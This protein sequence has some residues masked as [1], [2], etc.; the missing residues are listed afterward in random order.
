MMSAPAP[1]DPLPRLTAQ[2]VGLEEKVRRLEAALAA[3]GRATTVSDPTPVG[4]TW[5]PLRPAPDPDARFVTLGRVLGG[6]AHDLNNLLA[7]VQGYAEVLLE[8]LPADSPHREA[9]VTIAAV[10]DTAAGVVEHVQDVARSEVSSPA[11]TDPSLEVARLLR[12]LRAVCGSGV[13]VDADL[14]PRVGL[15]NVHPAELTQVLLHLAADARDAMPNGGRFTVQTAR[16]HHAPAGRPA[17][18]Y[19]VL[20]AA[21]TGPDPGPDR[22]RA[23]VREVVERAGGAVAV[24][25]A[26]GQGTTVRVYFRKA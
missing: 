10:A 7:V 3:A 23:A 25:R 8:D 12:V 22:H 19:I 4:I 2:L 5:P 11:Y 1:V 6:V 21:D 20:V 15:A 14:G 17:G 9:V 26:S 13:R 24:E 16:G 18:D